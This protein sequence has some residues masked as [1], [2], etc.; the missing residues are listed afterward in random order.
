MNKSVKPIT[1]RQTGELAR[2]LEERGVG[3]DEFQTHFLDGIGGL[4]DWVHGNIQPIPYSISVNYN[5]SMEEAIRAGNYDWY[6][7]DITSKH[8]PTERSGRHKVEVELVHFGRDMSTN[9]VLAE[10]DKC[11][12]RPAEL[13]ELLAFG[14]K[15]PEIQRES[16]IIALG[17]V[18]QYS[19]VDDY[20]PCLS[21]GGSGR[22]L[23]LGWVGRDWSSGCRFAAVRK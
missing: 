12:L 16:P 23:D 13:H 4:M 22:D 1:G 15:Y 9:N 14:A 21:W 11:G 17:S 18:W 5:Q 20:C 6:N 3:K 10:L 7:D 8:F 2:L 19:S